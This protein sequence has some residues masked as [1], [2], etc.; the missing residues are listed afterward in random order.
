MLP[1]KPLDPQRS[2]LP[3]V[4]PTSRGTLRARPGAQVTA[5]SPSPT[6]NATRLVVLLRFGGAGLGTG[7]RQGRGSGVDVRAGSCD[8]AGGCLRRA[9]RLRGVPRAPDR[10]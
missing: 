9:A 7:S 5:G 6:A 3:T 10:D 1:L 8:F 4:G 2:R